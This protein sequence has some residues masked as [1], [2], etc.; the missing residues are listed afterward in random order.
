MGLVPKPHSSSHEFTSALVLV[1][2]DLLGG[3][4]SDHKSDKATHEASSTASNN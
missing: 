1:H 3:H 2:Q 4:G